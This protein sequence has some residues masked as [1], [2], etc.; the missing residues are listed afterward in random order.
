MLD[1]LLYRSRHAEH[2]RRGNEWCIYPMY[3]FAHP[4]ADAIEDITHSLCTLEFDNDRELYDWVLDNT[5]G[6]PRP[7]QYEFA[8]ANL[9][10][11]VMSKRKLLRLVDEG[12]VSG[13]DDPRLPT[14]AGFRRRGLEP[15][16]I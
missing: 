5:V 11:T 3:D 8:R 13:W 9:D 7:H 4:L 6:N 1:P 14:L 15:A 16:A 10:Y 2:Y 12:H